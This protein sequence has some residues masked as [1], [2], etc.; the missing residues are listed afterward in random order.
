MDF[1]SENDCYR[2]TSCGFASGSFTLRN[3]R[4]RRC[5]HVCKMILSYQSLTKTI[6]YTADFFGFKCFL[7]R[8][9]LVPQNQCN[10]ISVKLPIFSLSES[11]KGFSIPAQILRTACS[12]EGGSSQ[13][14][15]VKHSGALRC[16]CSERVVGSGTGCMIRLAAGVQTSSWVGLKKSN[17]QKSPP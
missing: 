12:C 9:V 10:E 6:S 17:L 3:E 1:I 16:K 13:T 7:Q 5:F 2:Q 11:D 15:L 4:C 14:G 8:L